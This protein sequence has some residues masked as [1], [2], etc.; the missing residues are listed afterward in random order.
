MERSAG[1][2]SRTQWLSGVLGALAFCAAQ[3]PLLISTPAVPGISAPGW[4][5]NSGRSVLLV[6]S[7]LAA[8]AALLCARKLASDRDAVLYGIGAVMAIVVTLF[9]IGPGTIFP[10]VI[11]FGIGIVTFAVGAGAT[12]GAA[13]RERRRHAG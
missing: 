5:L 6:G 3:I 4:F 12:F 2:P 10:I 11:V 13:V 9:V 1:P 8:G 7:V